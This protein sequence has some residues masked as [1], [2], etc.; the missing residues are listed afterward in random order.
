VPGIRGKTAKKHMKLAVMNDSKAKL[1]IRAQE[2]VTD[3][4]YIANE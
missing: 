2:M 1:Q 3:V 4:V